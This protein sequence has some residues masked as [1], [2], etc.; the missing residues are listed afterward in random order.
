MALLSIGPCTYAF[1]AFP[2][3]FVPESNTLTYPSFSP[4]AQGRLTPSPLPFFSRG[5][6]LTMRTCMHSPIVSME[7]GNS[8]PFRP[9]ANP[10]FLL[11]CCPTRYLSV[12]R[13]NIPTSSPSENYKTTPPLFFT[14]RRANQS[15]PSSPIT[16]CASL[17]LSQA[18]GH[19]APDR[20]PHALDKCPLTHSPLPSSAPSSAVPVPEHAGIMKS[21][22]TWRG[23]LRLPIL[24]LMGGTFLSR[25]QFKS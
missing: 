19:Q 2:H 15:P 5:R 18:T 9:R 25:S 4:S 8:R 6:F 13:P 22:R 12:P 17:T 7:S 16:F 3:S 20:R 23:V 21:N 10:Q 24:S 11:H 1:A 14:P